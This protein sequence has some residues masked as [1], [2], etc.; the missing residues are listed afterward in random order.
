MSATEKVSNLTYLNQTMGGNK[1]LVKEIIDVFL[2]QAQEELPSINMAINDGNY[3]DIKRHA[4]AIK[5][6]ANI[7]GILSMV[8]I[9][10]QM[11]DMAKG[12]RDIAQIRKLG[13]AL[14]AIYKQA[15]EEITVS[16]KE[17]I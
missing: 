3:A 6:S 13:P 4:D 10:N 14:N 5:S 7:M 1:K 11:E 16:R 15:V 12:E 8:P 17:Y 2:K 9:L